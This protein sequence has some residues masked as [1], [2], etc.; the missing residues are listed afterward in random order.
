MSKSEILFVVQ[1]TEER[2]DEI[3]IAFRFKP[4]KRDEVS[5]LPTA[6]FARHPPPTLYVAN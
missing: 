1:A 4:I 2:F 3:L 6:S 5:S